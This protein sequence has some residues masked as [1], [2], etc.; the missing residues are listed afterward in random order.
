MA[1]ESGKEG[2]KRE[3]QSTAS[4]R[5]YKA[6]KISSKEESTVTTHIRR[7]DLFLMFFLA[8]VVGGGL[9]VGVLFMT[10]AITG[11]ASVSVPGGEEVA[12]QETQAPV[13]DSP[14]ANVVAEQPVA[15]T[16]TTTT[17]PATQKPK[18]PCGKDVTINLGST[19]EYNGRPIKATLIGEFAAQ[20]SVGGSNPTLISV[21][22]IRSVNGLNIQVQDTDEANGIAVI[23][24]PC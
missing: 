2:N 3:S 17:A 22:E 13:I 20:L 6:E 24:M 16:T 7:L 11:D 19:Y 23:N 8:F 9:V 21:G 5:P 1:D 14:T 10:G 12:S 18:D 4:F 15:N